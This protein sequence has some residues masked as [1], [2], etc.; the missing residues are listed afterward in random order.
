MPSTADKSE[1]LLNML[2]KAWDAKSVDGYNDLIVAARQYLFVS[3]DQP[4][5]APDISRKYEPD[6]RVERQIARIQAFMDRDTEHRAG[7]HPTLSVLHARMTILVTGQIVEANAAAASLFGEKITCLNDLNLDYE[8]T[9]HL[10]RI[11]SGLG[12]GIA[13]DDHI[14]HLISDDDG[15]PIFALC[16]LVTVERYGARVRALQ[17]SL[18]HISWTPKVLGHLAAS[19]HLTPSEAEVLGGLLEGASQKE[20]AESRDRSI[21]T[22][23]AQSKAIL[24]KAGAART[25]DLVQLCTG[26]AFLL[27]LSEETG[28]LVTAV[29]TRDEIRVQQTLKLAD[30]RDLSFH[31]YGAEFGRPVMFFHG[32]MQ[33]PYFTRAFIDGLIENNIALFCPSRPGFGETDP[34]LS[35]AD[36]DQTVINDTLALIRHIGAT[37]LSFLVLHGGV[38]HAFRVAARLGRERCQN[39]LM[40][41]AGIPID[42]AYISRMERQTQVAAYA[43]KYAP[44]VIG[45]ITRMAIATYGKKKRAFLQKLYVDAPLD[46]ATLD[47]P[48][49]LEIQEAGGEHVIGRGPRAFIDDGRAAMA[50]WHA[51]FEAA[52]DI[53]QV[54][55]HPSDCPVLPAEFVTE[56]VET[57]TPYKVEVVPRSGYNIL[58][59]HSDLIIAALQRS[60]GIS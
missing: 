43:V 46:L 9:A 27:T 14:Q 33:G 20:I 53:M 47:D 39:M 55:I 37:K 36:F 29:P 48:E 52:R 23:K 25:T 4:E 10:Q 54:W 56:Y 19:M 51:D 16:H 21:D 26:M 17:L 49:L 11:L 7:L 44:P 5:L 34:P 12:E 6:Q 24:R 2:D 41:D 1:R 38:S 59:T 28:D 40:V 31:V 22:V 45:L 8:S 57:R 35:K 3:D 42:E 13:P 30:G 50:D 15:K 58:H 60:L 18:S 32:Q